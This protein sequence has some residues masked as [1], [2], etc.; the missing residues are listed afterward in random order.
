MRHIMVPDDPVRPLA[1]FAS[2]EDARTYL[3]TAKMLGHNDAIVNYTH[4]DLGRDATK[5]QHV[6]QRLLQRL[7]LIQPVLPYEQTLGYDA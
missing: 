7:L 5:E 6:M 3:D 1:E 2:V 4:E